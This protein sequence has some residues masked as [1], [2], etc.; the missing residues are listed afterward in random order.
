[1]QKIGEGWV[2][3]TLLYRQIEKAFSPTKV[4]QHASPAFLGKQHYD[5]Y[6]PEYKIALE[7]QGDQHS[8]PI[9]FFGGEEAFL[10]G[11]ERDKRKR[12]ISSKNG[13]HQIDVYPGYDLRVVLESVASRIYNT[14]SS[15]YQELVTD[16]INRAENASVTVKDL[17]ISHSEAID[18]LANVSDEAEMD[19]YRYELMMKRMLNAK[20]KS[21][22]VDRTNFMDLPHAVF[23]Q[24]LIKLEEVKKASQVDAAR[25]NELAFALMSS[26]Y[27]APAIYERIAINYR[28]LGELSNELDILLQ[29]KKDFGYNFDD[30]IKNLLKKMYS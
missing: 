7:Y 8:R 30:R 15:N 22:A 28:K 18:K 2:S 21:D 29:A 9:E 25:S 19:D 6:L 27:H 13:V 14:G 12:E 17:A 24:M 4:M 26:G 10:K 23:E 5:V 1:M 20:K 16:A 3:E 11:L